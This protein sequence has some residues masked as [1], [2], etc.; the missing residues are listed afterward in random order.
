M[1]TRILRAA[2][3]GTQP[4][5][6]H[7]PQILPAQAQRAPAPSL[8]TPREQPSA[9]QGTHELWAALYL[10]GIEPLALSQLACAALRFTPRVSLAPPDGVLLE[11]RGSLHLFA[12]LEGLRAE[13]IQE[14]QQL[15]VRPVPA[16]A[17]TALAALVAA[18]AGQG[19]A[20]TDLGE[21]IGPPAPLP[22][23]ALR[24]PPET[25]AR[26]K[27][28]G[29][30]TI[31]AA[32]RL[33]RAGFAR[34]VGSEQLAM[35]DVLTGRTPEARVTLHAP[36]RSRRRRE[37][38]CELENQQRLAA[39]LSPLFAELGA[40]LAARQCAVVEFECRCQH[41]HVPATRCVVRL[42]APASDVRRLA[43]LLSEQLGSLALP[44]PV[45]SCE[46]R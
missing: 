13:L 42:A 22:L 31:G 34:R 41:R 24:W 9:G 36:E 17:P 4:L 14:C 3:G 19:L 11:V 30:R 1:R 40:F 33:P 2:S 20:V 25:L 44:E 39:A 37:L 43:A 29:V 12:G 16:F 35:L 38:D 5:P 21:L 6:L 26:L 23:A 7:A 27:R 18:R 10:P 45:R 15:P 28:M 46:L 8:R 32:L